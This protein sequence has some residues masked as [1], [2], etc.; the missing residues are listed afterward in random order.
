SGAGG[1]PAS[2]RALLGRGAGVVLGPGA[3]RERG[4]GGGRA[5]GDAA[6][7]A[8]GGG[9]GAGGAGAGPAPGEDPGRAGALASGPAPQASGHGGDDRDLHRRRLGRG[10]GA[11]GGAL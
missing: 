5:A 11:H 8:A 2:P 7:G 3:P 4:G 6:P 9:G 1:P 10:L